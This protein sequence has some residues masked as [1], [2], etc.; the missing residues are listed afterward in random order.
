[1]NIIK[2]DAIDSTNS[3][4]KDL[5]VNSKIEDFTIV[6]TKEQTS[7]RGQMHTTWVSETGKN[8]LCSVFLKFDSLKITNQNYLNYTISLSIYE[9]LEALGVSRLA[10]KW[11]ND[12]MSGNQKVCGI[13]IENNVSGMQ[14]SS[15]IVG[16]GLNVNQE[17]FSEAAPNA[18]SLKNILYQEFDIDEV[19]EIIIQKLKGNVALLNEEQF[20]LLENKYL[21]VLYKKN[22]P[23]MFKNNHQ[24]AFFMGKIIGVSSTGKLLIEFE[25]ETIQEFDIKEVSFA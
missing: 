4:L 8:L 1:M 10:I 18:V 2:L 17:K 14:I 24:N 19:L 11:P 23:S 13:L 25:N 5:S 7:G 20:H 6:T 15:S 21:D 22:V 9:A 16:I 12:I 3:F